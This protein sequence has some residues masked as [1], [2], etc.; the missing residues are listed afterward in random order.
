M[1]LRWKRIAIGVATVSIASVAYAQ[2]RTAHQLSP[3]PNAQSDVSLDALKQQVQSL[4]SQVTSIQAQIKQATDTE[5]KSVSKLKTMQSQEIS[6]QKQILIHQAQ[7]RQQAEA[8]AQAR[9][10]QAARAAQAVSRA[11]GSG[12]GGERGGDD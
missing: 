1:R 10:A 5:S 3:S 2:T 12:D 8:A 11:S 6:M 4:D 7:L 9:E